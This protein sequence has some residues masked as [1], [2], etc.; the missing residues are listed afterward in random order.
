MKE[1]LEF[2]EK[3]IPDKFLRV[4]LTFSFL[5]HGSYFLSIFFVSEEAVSSVTGMLKNEWLLDRYIL[6][7]NFWGQFVAA[8]LLTLI[9]FVYRF[10]LYPFLYKIELRHKNNLQSIKK[11]EDEELL[12]T[13]E[14]R[15]KTLSKVE[16]ISQKVKLKESN[17]ENKEEDEFEK[18][19]INFKKHKN[20][21]F[22]KTLIDIIYSFQTNGNLGARGDRFGMNEGVIA[23]FIS[24]GIIEGVNGSRYS[25]VVK[26][27]KKGDYFVK[28]YLD[29][30]E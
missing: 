26:F 19:Y 22:L 15:D 17:L 27:T 4:F 1:L 18:D 7:F 3:R 8:L 25:Q 13:L 9:Y 14:D 10:K 23:Y 30:N 5:F 21:P 24:F 20:F 28:R 11:Q 16:E 29:E 2:F 12:K 6:T